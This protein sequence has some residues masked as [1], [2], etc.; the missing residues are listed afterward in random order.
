MRD[1]ET[2]FCFFRIFR[3]FSSCI[4]RFCF[5][6]GLNVSYRCYP[7]IF[8]EFLKRFKVNSKGFICN[9]L[10]FCEIEIFSMFRTCL[11]SP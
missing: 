1:L 4:A 7:Y 8:Y 5:G 2:I 6:G 3:R 11:V 9:D 10:V